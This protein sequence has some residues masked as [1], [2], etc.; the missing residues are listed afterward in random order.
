[1]LPN[2]YYEKHGELNLLP[3]WAY[4]YMNLG[5]LIRKIECSQSRIVASLA[6][7]TR[8]YSAAL[9]MTG[10][11]ISAIAENSTSDEVQVRHILNQSPGTPVHVRRTN[12][13]KLKG[14]IVDFKERNN[15][16]HVVIQTA[17]NEVRWYDLEEYA[18]RITVSETEITVPKN[19]QQGYMLESP[20]SFLEGLFGTDLAQAHVLESSFEALVVG[21]TTL[22]QTEMC[23][24]PFWY[25]NSKSPSHS[26]SGF[27]QDIVRIQQFSGANHAYKAQCISSSSS[28][29]RDSAGNREPPL[30][31][32]DG[33]TAFLKHSHLWDKVHQII[34][35]DRTERQFIDAVEAVNQRH[36]YRL[37]DVQ[38]LQIRIPAGIELMLFAEQF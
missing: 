2:L 10:A 16:K 25:L 24:M 33:A 29:S 9:I 6:V 17:S 12:G 22:L 37:H 23:E 27:L 38:D 28:N 36:A 8:A 15:K 4:F 34:I 11:V 31:I 18:S 32:F 3:E 7:P 1:V 19:Q 26:R 30:V 5:I 14:I 20:S 35:L 13:R 21:K